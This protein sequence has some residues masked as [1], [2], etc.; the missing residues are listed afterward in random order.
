[1]PSVPLMF[2]DCRF[3]SMTVPVSGI[4]PSALNAGIT[5]VTTTTTTLAT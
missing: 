2:A 3:V 1:M 4:G 5:R